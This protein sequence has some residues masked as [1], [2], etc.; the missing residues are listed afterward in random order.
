MSTIVVIV[1]RAVDASLLLVQPLDGGFLLPLMRGA[2]RQTRQPLPSALRLSI[3]AR[4][5]TSE[6]QP[7]PAALGARRPR[8]PAPASEGE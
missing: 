4:R 1:R 8:V 5:R 2:S 6:K 3:I 7:M